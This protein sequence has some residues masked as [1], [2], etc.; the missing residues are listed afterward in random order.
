MTI[1]KTKE[2]SNY[3]IHVRIPNDLATAT[4]IYAEDQDRTLSY[5]VRQALQQYLAKHGN[6]ADRV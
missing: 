1:S 6:R 4:K 3:T 2:P 5:V